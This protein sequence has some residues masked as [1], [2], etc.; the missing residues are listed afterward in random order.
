M[1]TTWSRRLAR[2][3]RKG[4][5][6]TSGCSAEEVPKQYLQRGASMA[7]GPWQ[8]IQRQSPT[9]SLVRTKIFSAIDLHRA[10]TLPRNHTQDT[11]SR[12]GTLAETVPLR[13][14]SGPRLRRAAVRQTAAPCEE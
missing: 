8:R 12:N 9:L 14:A 5:P 10:K 1:V 7:A 13:N 3:F 4:K 2:P 6:I 11:I